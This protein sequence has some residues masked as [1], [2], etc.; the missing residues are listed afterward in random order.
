MIP[1]HITLGLSIV[2]DSK[3]TIKINDDPR[4]LIISKVIIYSTIWGALYPI[5]YPITLTSIYLL[6]GPKKK[7]IIDIYKSK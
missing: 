5:T 7:F 3:V 1:I 6:Y 2:L 4:W